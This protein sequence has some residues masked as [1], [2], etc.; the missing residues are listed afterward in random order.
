MHLRQ[1]LIDKAAARAAMQF[2]QYPT[3]SPIFIY[4]QNPVGS[5]NILKKQT[6]NKLSFLEAEI[7]F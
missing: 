3:A 1:R 2:I 7:S 4:P 5:S 6:P